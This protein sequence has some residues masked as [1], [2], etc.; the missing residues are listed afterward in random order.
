MTKEAFL[1][2]YQKFLRGECTQEEIEQLHAYHDD[3]R[4]EDNEWDLS[5]DEQLHIYE[6]I[7][8]RLHES[9]SANE[10]PVYTKAAPSPKRS[11]ILLWARRAAAAIIIGVCIKYLIDMAG[12]FNSSTQPPQPV[13]QT[14]DTG[15]QLD[16][17]KTWLTLGNGE[18]IS[19]TDAAKGTIVNT[20]GIIATKQEDG[21]V[22]FEIINPS[23]QQAF[24]TPDT[25]RVQTPCGERFALTLADG[26]KVW[27]NASSRLRFPA[28]FTGNSREVYLTGEGC[29]EVKADPSRPFIVH[30]NGMAV[31]AVGTLFNIKSY[32]E[33]SRT[34]ATLLSGKV[35]VD[36][37]NTRHI[38]RPGQQVVLDTDNGRA[39]IHNANTSTVLAWR[40][41]VFAF[42]R[43][44]IATIMYEIGRWYNKEIVFVKGN[45]YKH[46]TYKLRRDEP[47]EEA[48]KRL[49]L[50]G[51]QF[52]TTE[53]EIM[54][55]IP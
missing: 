31:Q 9:I 16:A 37:S 12:G 48:L 32:S 6:S 27:L 50:T 35:N 52:N 18:A 15:Q 25:H 22:A 33:E 39:G 20:S 41:G 21:W 13:A 34:I 8:A 24:T 28:F 44:T 5:P 14:P 29:F 51:I 45:L 3:M 26:S 43:E 17:G 10:A 19:L 7:K 38:L 1:L 53:R 54:V 4:L 47:L 55:T 23:A 2:L 30:T 46:Y 42:E 49:E 36:L 11:V 40:D